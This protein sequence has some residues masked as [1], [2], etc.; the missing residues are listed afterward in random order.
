MSDWQRFNE[1]FRESEDERNE[2][3][4]RKRKAAAA[5]LSLSLAD[6][7]G[8]LES[9]N[10]ANYTMECRIH[11]TL[12]FPW[13]NPPPAYTAKID[14]ALLLVP[15]DHRWLLDKRPYADGGRPDGYRAQVYRG[16]HYYATAADMPSAW[17]SRPGLALCIAALKARQSDDQPSQ[18]RICPI[19]RR[20]FPNGGTCR[21]GGCPMGGDV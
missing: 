9:E 16:G 8:R 18:Q 17:A 14:D 10:H 4:A 7:I 2:R 5:N 13:M 3:L 19:C 1:Q 15:P 20:D 12:G 6:L 11:E 21:I